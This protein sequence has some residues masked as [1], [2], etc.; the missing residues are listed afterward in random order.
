MCEYD[1]C[2]EEFALILF[3]YLNHVIVI[4]DDTLE[5]ARQEMAVLDS[6]LF[7]ICLTGLS[8]TTIILI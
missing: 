7:T 5:T 3:L 2:V 8:K 6:N 4:M 1:G